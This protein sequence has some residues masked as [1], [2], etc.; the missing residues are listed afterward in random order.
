MTDETRPKTVAD[1]RLMLNGKW[2][3]KAE[4]LPPTPTAPPLDAP[5]APLG[6]PLIAD[7]IDAWA[8]EQEPEVTPQ[9]HTAKPAKFT[10]AKGG[11]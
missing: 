4:E 7:D 3:P 5:S 6:E 8:D 1:V 10:K 2:P 11:G 9:P